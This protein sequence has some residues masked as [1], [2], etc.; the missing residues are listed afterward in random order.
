VNN[1]QYGYHPDAEHVFAHTFL[2]HHMAKKL[3]DGC[4][5]GCDLACAKGGENVTLA[6]GPQVVK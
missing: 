1:Y 6:R 3:P 5:L 4:Y 2:D